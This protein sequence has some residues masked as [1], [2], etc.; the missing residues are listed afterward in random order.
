MPREYKLKLVLGGSQNSGKTTF[1]NSNRNNNSPIGVSFESVEC[2][3]NEGDYFKFIVWD[4]KDSERFR[5]LFPLFC[6]GASAGLL[7]VDLSDIQSFLDLTRWITLFRKSA[8]GIPIILI[9]TKADLAKREVTDEIINEFVATEGIEYA[10]HTSILNLDNK[11]EE[12]FKTL[13]QTINPNIAIDYFHISKKEDDEEF[14][15][16][17]KKINCCPICKK[18]NHHSA[19]LKMVYTNKT[20][21]NTMGLK[22]NLIRLVDNLD[23]I[24]FEYPKISVGIP[25]CEC[26]KELFD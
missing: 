12:V 19:N 21:P 2:F 8:G 14:K 4:L 20:D 1:I 22:E 11:T 23:I 15:I 6:R 24:N 26:Y 7:C 25:C 16:L 9:G 5:F 10:G 18:M 3:V 17:E 13:V